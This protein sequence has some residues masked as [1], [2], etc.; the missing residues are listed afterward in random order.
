MAPF[1]LSAL[2]SRLRGGGSGKQ[3][4]WPVP[5]ASWSRPFGLGWEQPYTVRYAS[6]LDDGPC[7][8]MPWASAP[9]ALAALPM[10]PSTSGTSTGASTGLAPCPI[11][12]LP[13]LNGVPAAAAPTPWR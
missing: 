12:S 11:A 13:C 10:A 2:T 8:G 4:P 6:N 7:H 1:G 9:A 5:P 3:G